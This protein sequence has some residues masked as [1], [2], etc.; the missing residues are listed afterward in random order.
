MK[1]FFPAHMPIL[2]C[3][4]VF[5]CSE[6]VGSQPQKMEVADPGKITQKDLRASEVLKFTALDYYH[7]TG[8]K[9]SS[10]QRVSFGILKIK[11]KR[12]LKKNP[13]LLISDFYR[14]NK[15]SGAGLVIVIVLIFL[16]LLLLVVVGM[17]LGGS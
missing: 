8:K 17:A 12:E 7:F 15:K 2:F 4:L 3:L 6:A 16:L 1:G 10:W 14:D 5:L 9:M 11:L 13:D